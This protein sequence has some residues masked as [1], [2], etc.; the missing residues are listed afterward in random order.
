MEIVFE[1]NEAYYRILAATPY[2]IE[3]LDLK[4][5]EFLEP[6]K[7]DVL[8][9][10]LGE[11]YPLEIT[12]YAATELGVPLSDVLELRIIEHEDLTTRR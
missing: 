7:E 8:Y 5:Y 11:F 1:F 9:D 10:S 6:E 3:E 2:N 4:L 12:D